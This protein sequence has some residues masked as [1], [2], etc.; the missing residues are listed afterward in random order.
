MTYG[1]ILAERVPES[2]QTTAPGKH[3]IILGFR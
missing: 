1:P 3:K 2:E